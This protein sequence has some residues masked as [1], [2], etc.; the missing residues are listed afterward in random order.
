MIALIFL[1]F[2]SK[3]TYFTACDNKEV[4]G[5]RM[6]SGINMEKAY[7]GLFDDR[8]VKF[9]VVKLNSFSTEKFYVL[10]LGQLLGHKTELF[11]SV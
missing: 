2:I 9:L 6:W 3:L 5:K 8:I 11:S 7:G 4:G 10:Y 1:L